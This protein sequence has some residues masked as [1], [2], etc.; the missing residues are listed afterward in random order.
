[1]F[2]ID[3]HVVSSLY[4]EAA[5]ISN[6]V[7]RIC[8]HASEASGM[9]VMLIAFPPSYKYDYICDDVDGIMVYVGI[10]GSLEV[11]AHPPDYSSDRK[12]YV[13]NQGQT[14]V[15]PRRFWRRS[16]SGTEGAVFLECIEGPYDRSKRCT[17]V[18][19]MGSRM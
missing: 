8:Y 5:Q 2:F 13:F 17:S 4:R 6:T 15:L 1:M 3:E 19:A 18:R 9:Q 11:E 14:L 7:K 16:M 10:R 12:V